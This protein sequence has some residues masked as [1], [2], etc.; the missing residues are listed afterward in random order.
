MLISRVGGAEVRLGVRGGSE[1]MERPGGGKRQIMWHCVHSD[2][3]LLLAGVTQIPGRVNVLALA[4]RPPTPRKVT[5]TF[6]NQ[7]KCVEMH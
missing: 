4:T 1:R 7:I 5:L 3:V 6:S 2:S